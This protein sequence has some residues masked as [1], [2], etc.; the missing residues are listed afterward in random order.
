MRGGIPVWAFLSPPLRDPFGP[1]E[2]ERAKGVTARAPFGALRDFGRPGGTEECA[3]LEAP[4]WPFALPPPFRAR[5]D[6]ERPVRWGG[7][8]VGASRP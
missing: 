1:R 8:A 2:A 5:T 6:T 4:F 3:P 7:A